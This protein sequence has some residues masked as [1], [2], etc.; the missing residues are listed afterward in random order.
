M[1]PLG[2]PYVNTSSPA[3]TESVAKPTSLAY[4]PGL[5]A[6]SPRREVSPHPRPSS[7]FPVDLLFARV[8]DRD[9]TFPSQSKPY[10]HSQECG[11][12]LWYQHEVNIRK[13]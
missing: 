7:L 8:I 12:T 9:N 6:M 11:P 10:P 4:N 2:A 3:L 1:L 5:T 13:Q